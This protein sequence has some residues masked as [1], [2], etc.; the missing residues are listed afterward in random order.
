MT[1]PW[2]ERKRCLVM[3]L[4]ICPWSALLQ[5]LKPKK[6]FCQPKS[7]IHH[8]NPQT[9]FLDPQFCWKTIYRHPLSTDLVLCGSLHPHILYFCLASLPWHQT[10]MHQSTIILNNQKILDFSKIFQS[11]L[12]DNTKIPNNL[13]LF[14]GLTKLDGSSH[15]MVN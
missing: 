13:L 7:K 10:R 2:T 9:E 14:I 12:E 8:L 15:P 6:H 4:L 5:T 3:D 1:L 11:L